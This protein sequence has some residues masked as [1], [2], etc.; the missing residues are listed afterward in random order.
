M[1]NRLT[2]SQKI[3]GGFLAIIL[4]GT[5]LLMLPFATKQGES[6]SLLGAL[7]S[8]VSASCVTG[9]VAYDT[10]THWTAFGQIVL[11]IEM[12]IGGLGF[13]T[14]GT[15]LL[16]LMKRKIGVA[17][18]A[19]VQDSLSTLHL[20]G[21]VRLVRRIV[22]GTLFMEG[23]GAVLLSMRFIPEIGW[24]KGIYFGIFHS[25]SAFCNAG[26]D[27]FGYREP[28]SSFSHYAGD[29][30][31][32]LTLSALIVMGGIGFL[33][34]QD[35]WDYR[36]SI[37]KYHFHSKLVLL[38][39]GFL[40]IGSTLLFLI[41]EK[42]FLFAEMSGKEKFLAALF[43]AVTPRTAG[44]NSIDTAA[45][46]N[47]SYLLTIILMFIGGSPGS[48]AGGVKTITIL[49]ILVYVKSYL[50]RERDCVILNRRF[51][52]D[53]V[54]KASVVIFINLSLALLGVLIIFGAQNLAFKDVFFEVF[55]AIG[56]AGMTT[57]VTRDLNVISKIV[58][59]I[60][61]FSGRMG[62]L[63]F[64]MSFTEKT[65]TKKIRYPKDSVIIG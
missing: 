39:T 25:I 12:Q 22:A 19:L 31:V 61:M 54:R 51:D 5:F 18:R 35:I 24:K 3:R 17:R 60:L 2:N 11:L 43:S 21:N 28:Y 29:P 7:F 46:S 9:L 4:L 20:D 26:F 40:I 1:R 65:K 64:A 49:V 34:W 57:G 8:S 15:F 41:F 6:T 32:I 33:V 14:I 23:I 63:T 38:T 27:L 36:L 16:V 37:R 13:I 10:F 53:A 59:M 55:S 47:G 62:S 45:L 50:F 48:T 56:T 44:F 52:E 42:D 30:L 58:I